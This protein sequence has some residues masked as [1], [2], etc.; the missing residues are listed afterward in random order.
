[1]GKKVHDHD[2]KY[3]PKLLCQMMG[4]VIN[5]QRELN[6]KV[7]RIGNAT[8]TQEMN[9]NINLGIPVTSIDAFFELEAKMSEE[10]N[11]NQLVRL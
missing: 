3:G 10:V 7:D 6:E 1:M 9:L 11:L 8:Q 2:Q 5:N 4:K